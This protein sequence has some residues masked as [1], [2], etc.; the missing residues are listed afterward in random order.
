MITTKHCIGSTLVSIK[1]SVASPELE[2]DGRVANDLSKLLDM[3]ER[4]STY[5]R[6]REFSL[7]LNA[8]IDEI[9]QY[10]GDGNSDGE[11]SQSEVDFV[12]QHLPE[13]VKKAMEDIQNMN[14]KRNS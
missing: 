1:T 6:E 10:L 5:N 7:C 9:N 8:F 12:N 14:K 2:F 11:P 13:E 3:M 4:A